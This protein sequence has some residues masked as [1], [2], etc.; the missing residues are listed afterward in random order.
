MRDRFHT[1]LFV[2]PRR[3][4]ITR[5]L[6]LILLLFCSTGV[7]PGNII[8]LTNH[9]L[10]IEIH[11]DQGQLIATDHV[12]LPAAEQEIGF[13]LNA[14]V[15]PTLLD[16]DATL[17]ALGRLE[18]PVPLS[19][20]RVRF[21]SPVKGFS[22]AY[23]GTIKHPVTRAGESDNIHQFTPGLISGEGIFLSGS[24]Y[25]YPWTGNSPISFE[26]QVK[27]PEGWR[28]VSQGS[29]LAHAEGWREQHPQEE[30]YLIAYPYHYYQQKTSNHLAEVYLRQPKPELARRYLDATGEYLTLYEQL[31]GP[32]PYSKFALV[33]NFWESGYGMPS[34]TLLGPRVIRL[35]FII[36]T[37]Y[38]HEILHNWWGNGVYVDASSGNWSE[39]LTTYLADHLLQERQGKGAAYRRRTL[40]KYTDYVAS[41]DD[42]PLTRFRGNH[43][44]ISQS[45]GYGKALMLFHM[46]RLELGDPLFI[47]GLRE[48][49]RTYRFQAAGFA[50]LQATLEKVS[51]KALAPFFRQWLTRTGAPIL[52]LATADAVSTKDGYRLRVGIEQTQPERP[53]RL[54][55]PL[56][57]HFAD[58]KAAVPYTLEMDKRSAT[59]VIDTDKRPLRVSVDPLFD[60]F[61]RLDPSETPSSLGQLF[62]AKQL[63]AVLPDDADDKTR[64]AYRDLIKQWQQRQPGLTLLRDSAIEQ[65][66][67][68]GAVWILG[69]QNR[70]AHLFKPLVN[71][72]GLAAQKGTMALTLSRP[73]ET[74]Q[75]LGYIS[76]DNPAALAGLS[77]KLPHYSRY[78]YALFSGMEPT[79]QQRGEWQ[80]TDSAL[81]RWFGSKSAHDLPVIADH[82][83]LTG[84]AR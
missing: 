26:L 30:I 70:F 31:L 43:G 84:P 78:S 33:E 67:E 12:T 3:V 14:A 16:D 59:L 82:P 57:V 55:I 17:I 45:V 34:F 13:L 48:F 38:P 15:T 53:F 5:W 7:L 75:T 79:I 76:T 39:G 18:G 46:L 47:R 68:Q 40:Q 71:Q 72:Q 25:W 6:G 56:F 9:Q 29:H 36:H 49:Y 54:K 8:G 35:P 2:T 11:P 58:R 74:R 4:H 37:S 62:G 44:Q 41:Q 77:R 42:F 73:V 28:S 81:I 23:R 60:L 10:Q 64:Q 65:L 24:S 22:I 20:Y 69:R 51:G 1:D 83:V 63:F 32:Y 80:I 66:P 50:E 27:L 52:R 61:R 21:N 19:R